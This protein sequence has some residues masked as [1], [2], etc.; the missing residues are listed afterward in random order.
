MSD[1]HT[2]GPLEV[3]VDEQSHARM[4]A[5]TLCIQT[6]ARDDDGAHIAFAFNDAEA[7]ARLLAAA[8]T[9]Y[10][11]HCGARAVKCAEEDLLGEALEACKATLAY[12]Q[13]LPL[14][15]ALLHDASPAEQA[16]IEAI[17]SLGDLI[18][19]L[20]AVIAKATREG[21]EG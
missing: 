5:P 12:I 10:D 3:V 1:R 2:S 13:K 4:D 15:A 19:Q 21:T 16:V 18:R 14:S 6:V 8:Y 7:N 17:T 9:S 20:A 11:A